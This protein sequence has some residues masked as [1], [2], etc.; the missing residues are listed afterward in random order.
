MK[1]EKILRKI[2]E[3]QFNN[4]FSR[5]ILLNQAQ[6]QF[7]AKLGLGADPVDNASQITGRSPFLRKEF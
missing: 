7:F 4:Y 5:F 2:S 6:P 3:G 1:F